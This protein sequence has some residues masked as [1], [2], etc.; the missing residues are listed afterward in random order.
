MIKVQGRDTKAKLTCKRSQRQ[1]EE[2]T[3]HCICYNQV[4][5]VHVFLAKLPVTRSRRPPIQ[6]FIDAHR[7]IY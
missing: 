6:Y 4:N 3:T 1:C 7:K 5:K 2:N